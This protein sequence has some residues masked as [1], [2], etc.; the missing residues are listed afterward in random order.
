MGTELGQRVHEAGGGEK[1]STSGQEDPAGPSNPPHANFITF[2]PQ[3]GSKRG[4]SI[5][6][7][8]IGAGRPIF[9]PISGASPTAFSVSVPQTADRRT[10]VP[11]CFQSQ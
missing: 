3:A 9:L 8:G 5:T 10:H 4:A 6:T 1:A 7:T 11:D 2:P